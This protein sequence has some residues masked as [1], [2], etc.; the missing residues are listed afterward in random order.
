MK[1]A[2][3]LEEWRRMR[4]GSTR[5]VAGVAG[6]G[7]LRRER[8]RSTEE[9]AALVAATRA[10]VGQRIREGRLRRIGSREYRVPAR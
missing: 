8:P 4:A 2:F 1:R 9:R 5:A 3:T 7:R 10:L 6:A